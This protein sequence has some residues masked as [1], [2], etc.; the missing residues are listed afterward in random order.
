MAG[1]QLSQGHRLHPQHSPIEVG[2]STEGKER[3]RRQKTGWKRGEK[4]PSIRKRSNLLITIT[5]KR[6]H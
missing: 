1:V 4:E 5:I 6:G 2:R 3:A